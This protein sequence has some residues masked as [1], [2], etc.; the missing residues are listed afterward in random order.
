M[1]GG[2]LIVLAVALAALL[3][4]VWG[5]WWFVADL[6]ETVGG[7]ARQSSYENAEAR[8]RPAA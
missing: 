5:A 3:P 1:Y 4:V 8:L 6:G 2:V 7:S